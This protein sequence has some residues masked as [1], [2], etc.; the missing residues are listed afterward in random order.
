MS[1]IAPISA[2]VSFASTSASGAVA[3]GGTFASAGSDVAGASATGMAP[4]ALGMQLAG[5][6]QATAGAPGMDPM[7]ML[8]LSLLMQK[9]D[10][11]D[12]KQ[13]PMQALAM[14]A[15]MGGA[16]QAGQSSSISFSMSASTVQQ[17]YA[18]GAAASVSMSAQ[19]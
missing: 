17:A 2:N 5:S 19:A 6:M 8:A 15:M 4:G 9:G 13:D 12:D 1:G 10:K 11:S 7:T 16:Q 14:L 18:P 3:M